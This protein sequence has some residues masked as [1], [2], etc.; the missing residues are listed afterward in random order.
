MG[1][2]LRKP[3]TIWNIYRPPIDNDNID[4]ISKLL[5]ELS[6]VLDILQKEN[7]YA[8]IVGDFNINLLQINERENFFEGFFDFMCTNSF[9][10]KITLAPHFSKHSCSLIDKL[11][12]KFHTKII[13]IFHLLLFREI[14]RIIFLALCKST[15]YVK[16][17]SP[18]IYLRSYGKRYSHK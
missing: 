14:Y 11:F 5:S 17:T 10:P 2:N 16:V 7:S 9:Y 15:F 3:L 12:A 13:K 6:P 4:N 1:H 8:A 18:E